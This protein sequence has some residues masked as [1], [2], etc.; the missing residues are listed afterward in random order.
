M[1][2]ILLEA[3]LP[4]R[5]EVRIL[6]GLPFNSNPGTR[7]FQGQDGYLYGVLWE[8][9]LPAPIKTC[10]AIYQVSP[11]G[12][13]RYLHLFPYVYNQPTNNVGGISPTNFLFMGKDGYLYGIT[14][15]GGANGTGVSFRLGTDGSYEVLA[16]FPPEAAG[17]FDTFRRFVV[18]PDNAIYFFDLESRLVRAGLDG[19]FSFLGD[20]GVYPWLGYRVGIFALTA[21]NDDASHISV[22]WVK[23]QPPLPLEWDPIHGVFGP[24]DQSQRIRQNVVI[25]TV[26]LPSGAILSERVID[27]FGAQELD[28]SIAFL[29]PDSIVLQSTSRDIVNHLAGEVSSVDTLGN[30]THLADIQSAVP[31]ASIPHPLSFQARDGSMYFMAGVITRHLQIGL[32]WPEGSQLWQLLPG[33]TPISKM[34]ADLDGWPLATMCDS[35]EG[36]LYGISLGAATAALG[37]DDDGLSP[38]KAGRASTRTASSSASVIKKPHGAFRR[39]NPMD[40]NLAPIARSD[41]FALAAR[42]SITSLLAPVLRNDLDPEKGQLDLVSVSTPVHGTASIQAGL[43]GAPA[44]LLYTPADWPRHSD[45]FTYTIQ[46]PKGAP[47]IGQVRVRADLHG[48]FKLPSAVATAPAGAP[49][50]SLDSLILTVRPTG[51][52]VGS[53]KINGQPVALAGEFDYSDEAHLARAVRTTKKYVELHFTLV[54]VGTQRQL[55]YEVKYLGQTLSG[56]I[57]TK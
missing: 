28:P 31:S 4:A 38:M 3:V 7:F 9:N 44:Q 15:G 6:G 12:G 5:A 16:S 1:A 52:F 51:Q 22:A 27:Y 39:T 18:G 42:S 57:L 37:E 23:D 17:V 20:R 21:L 49:P 34:L 32:A 13:I 8:T 24:P 48:I 11:A 56:G 41:R 26:E 54:N 50:I 2:I 45:A 53:L 25:R 46:D 36:H 33:G 43:N 30:V 55:N 47:S 35:A 29:G 19:S 40:A 10:G 14:H